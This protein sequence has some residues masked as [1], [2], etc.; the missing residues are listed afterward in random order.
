MKAPSSDPMRPRTAGQ[1]TNAQLVGGVRYGSRE[2]CG[3]PFIPS[4]PDQTECIQCLIRPRAFVLPSLPEDS[5]QK[6]FKERICEVCRDPFMPTGTTQRK[7][8]DCGKK[9]SPIH[10]PS[11]LE[12]EARLKVRVVPPPSAEVLSMEFPAGPVTPGNAFFSLPTLGFVSVEA[13]RDGFIY[14]AHRK[15]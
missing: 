13:E 5:M 12:K 15:E 3:K 8:K 6:T 4:T 10:E 7:C 1:V 9:K 14:T 11:A 2:K